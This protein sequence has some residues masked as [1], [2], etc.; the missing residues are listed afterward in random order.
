MFSLNAEAER[1]RG[2]MLV[3][4]SLSPICHGLQIRASDGFKKSF[5]SAKR[6]PNIPLRQKAV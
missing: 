6:Q 5:I 3:T 2:E 1:Q 4:Y